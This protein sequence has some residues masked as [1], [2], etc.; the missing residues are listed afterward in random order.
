MF[1]YIVTKNIIVCHARLVALAGTSVISCTYTV[2]GLVA[3][4]PV[5]KRSAF[6]EDL[7]DR[8][9]D[10]NSIR[11]VATNRSRWR[12]LAAHCPVKDRRI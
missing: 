5:S 12:T 7:V 2:V 9:V 3:N 1:L 8:G 4:L 11:A 10:W 6:K